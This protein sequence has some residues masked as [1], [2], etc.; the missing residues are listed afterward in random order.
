MSSGTSTA[1][2]R[3]KQGLI[4]LGWALAGVVIAILLWALETNGGVA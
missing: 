4:S 2:R 3:V 1:G